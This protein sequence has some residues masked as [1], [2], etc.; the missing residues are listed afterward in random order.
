MCVD[1]LDVQYHKWFGLITVF[2]WVIEQDLLA[3]HHH[4]LQNTDDITHTQRHREDINKGIVKMF[5]TC[6]TFLSH[7]N[8]LVFL[9][10]RD[11]QPSRLASVVHRK[12]DV[13]MNHNRKQW[14]RVWTHTQSQIELETHVKIFS[15]LG[16]FESPVYGIRFVPNVMIASHDIRWEG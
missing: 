15:Q 13:F 11:S 14:Q 1:S 16:H 9:L 7:P 5:M 10:G 12:N 2:L 8:L 4:V 6:F 3:A